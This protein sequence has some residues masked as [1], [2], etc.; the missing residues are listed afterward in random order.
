MCVCVSVFVCVCVRVC[1]WVCVWVCACKGFTQW[2]C[3]PFYYE[4]KRHKH[5]DA[6]ITKFHTH[7]GLASKEYK[8]IVR[9][10]PPKLANAYN[11]MHTYALKHT[12]TGSAVV[13]N[14]TSM[15]SVGHIQGGTAHDS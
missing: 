9:D 2:C 12:Y 3:A 7:L 4:Q 10:T 11:E 14:S 1:V 6:W 13:W 15:Q 8:K 5:K